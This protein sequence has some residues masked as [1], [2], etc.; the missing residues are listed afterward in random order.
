AAFV[1]DEA[2]F[3]KRAAEVY[4][5][6]VSEFKR[7]FKW[8]RPSLFIEGLR[9]DLWA[10]AQ[11]LIK[12]LDKCG[13]WDSSRDAKLDTLVELLNV[14]NKDRKVLVFT[15]FADTVHYLVR[16]LQARG[17]KNMEGATGDT[18]NPTALAYR[19]SPESNKM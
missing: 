4:K 15:Q 2:S 11:A 8:L 12:V 18:E 6:Y 7:R 17:V 9:T 5:R 14:R 19:F 1:R 13:S 16:Q 10:D 3:R